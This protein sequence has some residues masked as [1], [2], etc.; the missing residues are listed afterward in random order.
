M[1][2]TEKILRRAGDIACTI[3]HSNEDLY[4]HEQL[5]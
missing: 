3:R 1:T 5:Y 2:S 4:L